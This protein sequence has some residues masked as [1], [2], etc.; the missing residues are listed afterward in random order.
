MWSL[1]S[2][3]TAGQHQEKPNRSGEWSG[4]SSEAHQVVF[5]F[6]AASSLRDNLCSLLSP[7]PGLKTP[8]AR[9]IEYL[10]EVAIGFARALANK[11]VSAKRSRG[12]MQSKSAW[13]NPRG[14]Q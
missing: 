2:L 1:L 5:G 14:Q 8:E 12:L 9:T 4:S 3:S 13:T 10:E 6:P 11:T 7:G